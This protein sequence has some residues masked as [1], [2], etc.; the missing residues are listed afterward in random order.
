M[1][2]ER[3]EGY[4]IDVV[5][6]TAFEDDQEIG[7]ETFDGTLYAPATGTT[8]QARCL[9]GIWNDKRGAPETYDCYNVLTYFESFTKGRKLKAKTKQDITSTATLQKLP[10]FK[11]AVQEE[12]PNEH[13]DMSEPSGAESDS[14]NESES[15]Y[16][17]GQ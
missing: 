8:V 16:S 13:V 4:G 5:K 9:T 1:Y 17:D 6:V 11:P 15:E 7:K 3:D 10:I 14:S 12:N 2:V